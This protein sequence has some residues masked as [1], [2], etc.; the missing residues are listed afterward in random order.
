VAGLAGSQRKARDLGPCPV[1][2]SVTTGPTPARTNPGG[3]SNRI[4]TRAVSLRMLRT[5]KNEAALVS[6]GGTTLMFRQA[7]AGA[8]IPCK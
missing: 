1:G 5:M 4:V 8:C 6:P 7:K 3:S 2:S